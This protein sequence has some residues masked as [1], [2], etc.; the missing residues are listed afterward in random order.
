VQR[1]LRLESSLALEQTSGLNI[2]R[3]SFTATCRAA[4]PFLFL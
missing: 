1:L 4:T 3:T 2:Q